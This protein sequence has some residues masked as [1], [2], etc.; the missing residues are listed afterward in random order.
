MITKNEQTYNRKSWQE[1]P[2]QKSFVYALQGISIFF[3][4]ERNG[5]LQVLI[6]CCVFLAGILLSV[7]MT[8]WLII[9][10]FT[11]LVISLEMLNS[12]LEKVCD[13]ISPDWHPHIKVIKDMAAGAVL[14]ASILSILAGLF[15][16]IPKII[17]L[18]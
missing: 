8:E 13:H 9:L 3:R 17:Q 11:A 2:L 10:L 5:R 6:A 18:I 4:S 16:F 15:I 14:W 12:A 1:G 7:S